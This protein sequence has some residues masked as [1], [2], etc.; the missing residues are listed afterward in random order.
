MPSKRAAALPPPI[1]GSPSSWPGIAF[2]QKNYPQ[3]I[4]R[5][6]QAIRLTP[7]D[8]YTNDFLGTTYFLEGNLE[9]AL[10]YWNRVGKPHIADVRED[11]VT[12]ISPAL[13]DHAFAFSPASTLTA[14]QFL[15][16]EARI[17]GLGIFPQFHFDLDA[18]T[19]GKFDV[20]FRAHELN[21][22]GD[23]K[24]EALLLFFQ[25]I[26][27]QEVS[28]RYYNL[29]REAINFDFHVSLGRAKAPHLRAILRAF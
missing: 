22:F 26:P 9:A 18:R 20:V 12:R 23:S 27:F 16:S 17:R 28:P 25:G 24:L 6:R 21:G 19:D 5:L 2:K 7:G 3:T 8:S 1:H 4:R 10:K 15:D 13:L 11:P 14:P 29:H